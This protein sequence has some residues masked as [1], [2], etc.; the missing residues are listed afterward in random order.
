MYERGGFPHRSNIP[1]R[2][3]AEAR[4]QLHGDP[5]KK[6]MWIPNLVERLN[7]AGH[8][9]QLLTCSADAMRV[10]LEQIARARHAREHRDMEHPPP[11]IPDNWVYHTLEEDKEYV[12]GFNFI[13]KHMKEVYQA[14]FT[15]AGFRVIFMDAAHLRRGA[16][17]GYKGGKLLAAPLLR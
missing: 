4:Q 11:F 10:R 8:V 17:H 3:L 16:G 5:Q 9:A 2:A 15:D 6:I 1:A 13:P 7:N 14:H 12:I